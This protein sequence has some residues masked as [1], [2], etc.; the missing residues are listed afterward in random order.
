M[1]SNPAEAARIFQDKKNPQHAFLQMG[2]KA[3]GPTSQICGMLKIPKCNVEA[4]I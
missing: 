4:G 3:V 2:S 1:G